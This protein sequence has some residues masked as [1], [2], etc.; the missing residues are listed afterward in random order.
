MRGCIGVENISSLMNIRSLFQ[1]AVVSYIILQDIDWSEIVCDCHGQR[2]VVLDGTKVCFKSNASLLG[3]CRRVPPAELPVRPGTRSD[4]LVF[5]AGADSSTVD[6]LLKFASVYKRSQIL[7]YTDTYKE[8]EGNYNHTIVTPPKLH[9][10]NTAGP[11]KRVTMQKSAAAAGTRTRN[12]RSVISSNRLKVAV[13][14]R[15]GEIIALES[16]NDAEGFLFWL[17]R[18]EGPAQ[19]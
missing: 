11:W 16:A 10:K 17:A 1:D 9:Q 14:V 7:P 4:K 18:A 12:Q 8:D 3:Q 5:L 15:A 19:K 6:L 2:G 13:A